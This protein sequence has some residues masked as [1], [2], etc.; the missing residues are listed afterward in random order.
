MDI[1]LGLGP[2][3]IFDEKKGKEEKPQQVVY[4]ML[5]ILIPKSSFIE[6]LSV[7]KTC[8]LYRDAYSLSDVSYISHLFIFRC[9]KIST[10]IYFTVKSI[11]MCH[12]EKSSYTAWRRS[13]KNGPY[14]YWTICWEGWSEDVA[15]IKEKPGHNTVHN[16]YKLKSF[17]K[18]IMA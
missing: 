17:D 7:K 8:L 10:N 9:G 16:D 6:D 2:K 13:L 14:R 1:R 15:I 12:I 18:L 4:S 3:R 5:K 11:F